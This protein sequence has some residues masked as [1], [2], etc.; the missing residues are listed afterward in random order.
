MNEAAHEAYTKPITCP[1]TLYGHC[2]PPTA[3]V[4]EV[5]M[6]TTCSVARIKERQHPKP[7]HGIK[8][9]SLP[10]SPPP[11][12]S[13]TPH[14][15][16]LAPSVTTMAVRLYYRKRTR[17]TFAEEFLAKIKV[18]TTQRKI[19]RLARKKAMAQRPTGSDALT[20][21][22]EPEPEVQTEGPKPT[23]VDIFEEGR[24]NMTVR[25]L[26]SHPSRHRR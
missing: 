1:K 12:L 21:K 22:P 24:K 26:L 17:F 20:T 6:V 19:A 11:L 25:H 2:E 10:S 16:Y 23:K 15:V 13:S 18:R 4:L 14:P 3:A 9:A 7:D 5:S 8:R